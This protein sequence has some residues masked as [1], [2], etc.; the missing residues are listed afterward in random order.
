MGHGGAQR[1]EQ[2]SFEP[3]IIECTKSIRHIKSVMDGMEV[4][5]EVLIRVEQSM[6]E[7]LPGVHDQQREEE[8]ANRN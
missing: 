3:M 5:I 1:I 6:E 2:E 8:L 7:I 4:P